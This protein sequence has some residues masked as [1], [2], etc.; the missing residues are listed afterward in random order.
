MSLS[1][2]PGPDDVMALEKTQTTVQSRARAWL[3]HESG[4]GLV[5]LCKL[6]K[7]RNESALVRKILRNGSQ[8]EVGI[9][10]SENLKYCL[11]SVMTDISFGLAIG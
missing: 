1:S 6:Q 7:M 11:H 3:S 4:F 2:I 5:V 8:R 9:E 10:K